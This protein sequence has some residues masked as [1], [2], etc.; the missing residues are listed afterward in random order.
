MGVDAEMFIK[1]KNPINLQ[2][3]SYELGCLFR[4]HLMFGYGKLD[5]VIKEHPIQPASN[6]DIKDHPELAV[7]GY[8]ILLWGRYYG[9]GYERGPILTYIEMAEWLEWRLGSELE[10]IL[11]GGDCGVQFINF[12][13][14]ARAELKHYYFEQ[15]HLPYH[16]GFGKHKSF[17]PHCKR[18]NEPMSNYGGGGGDSYFGCN[19]CN[20]KCIETATQIV[21]DWAD[22]SD[23]GFFKKHDELNNER[24]GIKTEEIL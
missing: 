20:Y 12:N 23:E 24:K 15:A 7:N 2:K 1:T 9:K 22:D 6:Y 16:R 10:L 3:L 14:E 13:K 17:I 4:Q 18:C 19:G 8:E 5:E 21:K 11:Y